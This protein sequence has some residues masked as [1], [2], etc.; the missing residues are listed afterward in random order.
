[1]PPAASEP[2][3]PGTLPIKLHEDDSL[4]ETLARIAAAKISGCRLRISC[5]KGLSNQ[6]THFLHSVEGRRIIGSD[7]HFYESE[8]DLINVMPAVDRIRYAAPERVPQVPV[9][10][11]QIDM[12]NC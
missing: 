1:M 6:V 4:F 5:P 2:D 9:A 3:R 10:Q 7:P 11:N 8:N 12:R